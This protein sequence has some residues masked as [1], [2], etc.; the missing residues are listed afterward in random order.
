[1]IASEAEILLAERDAGVSCRLKNVTHPGHM[2]RKG[3]V[4]SQQI[5]YNTHGV[6]NCRENRVRPSFTQ[7]K[8]HISIPLISGQ[9]TTVIRTHLPP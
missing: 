9:N 7:S 1:M 3:P 2:L 4:K 5:V 6:W 8:R